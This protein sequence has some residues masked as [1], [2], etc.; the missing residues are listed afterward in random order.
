MVRRWLGR[1]QRTLLVSPETLAADPRIV[2][3]ALRTDEL[4][5][6]AGVRRIAELGPRN[7]RFVA[8]GVLR[9][10]ASRLSLLRDALEDGIRM[11]FAEADP[12]W[13][14]APLTAA[15][16][17]IV[18]RL[19]DPAASERGALYGANVLELLR[20]TLASD[21]DATA[22]A[23]RGM[24]TRHV[25]HE[26]MR[27]LPA[28]LPVQRVHPLRRL[29]GDPRVPVYLAVGIYSA[30]RALPVAFLPQF[31]GNLLVLWLIDILTAIPYTWGVLAMLFAPRRSIRALATLTTIATFTAPYVYFWLNGRDYP[32]FV[33]AVIAVLTVCSISIE[34]VKYVQERLL[35]RRYR[36]ALVA[37]TVRMTPVRITQAP[38]ASQT[39]TVQGSAIG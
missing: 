5:E 24:S 30:L 10:P 22:R 15:L 1:M 4:L 19:D 28:E 20:H 21:P 37:A 14:D 25:P 35:R 8:P 39:T 9:H 27:M 3:R 34:V 29:A 16:P 26:T 6:V 2:S 7:T 31:H 32:P 11:L 38:E 36:S 12:A 23:L 18:H 17:G 33:V 13:D